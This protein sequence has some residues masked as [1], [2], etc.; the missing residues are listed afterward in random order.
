MAG[1]GLQ[2]RRAAAAPGT[3]AAVDQADTPHRESR[4]K[5]A[6]HAHSRQIPSAEQ[7]PSAGRTPG[8]ALVTK[9][10]VTW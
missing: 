9:S 3:L 10:G 8:A 5:T 2:Q 1:S 6:E 7:L 4:P